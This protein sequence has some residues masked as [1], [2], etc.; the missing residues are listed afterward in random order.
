[1]GRRDELRRGAERVKIGSWRGSHDVGLVTPLSG[2][3]SPGRELIQRA[4]AE[5]VRRGYREALTG[6]LADDELRGFE[7]CGFEERDTLHLLAHDLGPL[8]A[9]VELPTD[10]RL[11]RGNRFRLSATLRVDGRAFPPF[12]R[13]DVGGLQEALTATTDVR[14]RTART[15]GRIVGYAVTG[16]TRSMGY[17]QRLA[18]D[19]DVEGRGV[20]RALVADGLR[21]LRDR[22]AVQAVVNTQVDNSRAL[23]LYQS[24]GFVLLPS[25][26]TVLGRSLDPAPRPDAGPAPREGFASERRHGNDRGCG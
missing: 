1:M 6:A 25:G 21:W 15:E 5:L 8:L 14:F 10:V 23:G 24:I 7:A 3:L 22:G 26:L 11:A 18:V 17:L 9:R 13:L 4:C 2:P 19:P 16:L 20:G 12:W